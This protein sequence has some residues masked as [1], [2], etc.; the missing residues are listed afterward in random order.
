M[1]HKTFKVEVLTPE[2]KAFDDEVEMLSTRTST[3]SI[4][5]RA[6]HAPLMAI[7]DPTELRLY[8]G[9]SDVKSFAQGEG[10]LQVV[11]N[12]ALVLVDEIVEPDKLDRGDVEGR[13]KEAEQALESADEDSEEHRRAERNARRYRA[14]LEVIEGS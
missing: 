4:G 13:L 11:N 3:G 5:V 9:E 7:L 2:G 1:A 10:Y 6:N 8:T 12:S 14:F